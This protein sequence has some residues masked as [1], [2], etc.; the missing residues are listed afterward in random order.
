MR[1]KPNEKHEPWMKSFVKMKHTSFFS[2][3]CILLGRM[4][5]Q[6][7]RNRVNT[8]LFN[9]FIFIPNSHSV[10]EEFGI[11]FLTIYVFL[12]HFIKALNFLFTHKSLI[13]CIDT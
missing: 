6:E 1:I 11:V 13:I 12:N 3:L 2:H 7:R 4:F 8:I 10:N 9:I 5:L